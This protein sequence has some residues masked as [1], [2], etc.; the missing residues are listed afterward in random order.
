MHKMITVAQD[1]WILL[2]AVLCE[3]IA[4]FASL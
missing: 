3:G 2:I 1:W 4:I